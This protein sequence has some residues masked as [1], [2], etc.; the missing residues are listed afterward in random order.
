MLRS[1]KD[2]L[3]LQRPHKKSFSESGILIPDHVIDI[4]MR[5]PYP[6]SDI[7][8]LYEFY[9]RGLRGKYGK[10]FERQDHHVQAFINIM[11]CAAERALMN[12]RDFKSISG[13]LLRDL[14]VSEVKNDSN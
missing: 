4:A 13:E 14:L 3:K 7:V 1:L 10:N 12:C 11:D 6:N 5:Y 2:L 8:A 9:Y